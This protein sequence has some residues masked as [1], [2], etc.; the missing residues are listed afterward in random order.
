MAYSVL[1][2]DDNQRI[3]QGLREFFDREADFRVCGMAGNGSEAIAKAHELHPDLILMDLLMPVL[4]GFDAARVLKRVMPQVVIIMF[5][6]CSGSFV[7][8]EARSAGISAFVS[9]SER[10]SVLLASARKLVYPLTAYG[11]VCALFALFGLFA[12]SRIA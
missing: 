2:V 8:A 7:E 3:R 12:M 6:A 1:I 9:K 5:T 4:N 10:L 11:A